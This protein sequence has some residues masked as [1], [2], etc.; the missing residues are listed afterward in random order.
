MKR[1]MIAVGTLVAMTLSACG[2]ESIDSLDAINSGQALSSLPNET[3][4]AAG[5]N[6]TYESNFA[7]IPKA[8][9]YRPAG[10]SKKVPGKR[11]VIFHLLGCGELAY[12]IAQGSGWPEA[13]EAYGLVI[14][15]P[16]IIAPSYPNQAAPNVACYNFG[17]GPVSAPTRNS[18]DH[19]ALI[20]AGQKVVT[21]YPA[22]QIDPN[23][24]YLAGLSAGATVGMQV[25]CMAPD[26]FAGVASVAGPAIG[27]DQS[28]AVMP[29]QVTSTQI[30]NQCTS[31]A[32]GSSAPNPQQALGQQLYIIVSDDNGL[33]AGNPVMENGV[34]T[35]DKFRKQTIWDG[36]KYVPHAY[37]D[38]IAG[39]MAPLFNA[40][41][42]GTLVTL[43]LSGTG[44]GCPGGDKSRDDTGE[45][46]CAFSAAVSRSWT[47]KAD[48][49]KDAQGRTRI[50][51]IE[52]DTL[53]HRWPA[54]P[55]GPNDKTV[56]P[57]RQTLISQGYILSDGTFD[58][59][60]L[61][62]APNGVIGGIYFSTD[63]FDFPMYLGKFLEDNNPR[64]TTNPPPTNPSAPVIQT[65]TENVAAG[66]LTV[67]GT[68]SD[69]DNDLAKVELS[70]NIPGAQKSLCTGTTSFTCKQDLTGVAAGN[71]SG[72]LTAT[73]AAGQTHSV[74]FSFTAGTVNPPPTGNKCV[75]AKNSAHIWGGR[76][77]WGGNIWFP[78]AFA[79]G[80]NDPLG[81][82]S[83]W[84]DQ[85]T[86][87]REESP[88]HWVKVASCP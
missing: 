83:F 41:K 28:R 48:A 24:V 42:S 45:T 69:K 77:T 20:A 12:Q 49:W 16:E 25:A 85:T 60:K 27:A 74:S 80:S 64:I 33:P 4:W 78:T 17:S 19:K 71:Y 55:V 29:P 63:S 31:Y 18:A 53:R 38:L 52:Q 58:I 81:N 7:G 68:A 37:H 84:N 46:E 56:T 8:W 47:A 23:Q 59:P 62:G 40:Q 11:G 57:D 65:H 26:I 67:T 86:S 76:A 2:G 88:G 13:A 6:W 15:V 3:S 14:V 79:K 9:V 1:A 82:A 21:D 32:N 35:A 36:D 51:H 39:A 5:T 72:T 61:N 34:W 43:P 75:T 30:K 66:S 10:F 70:T 22:L 87:V 44:T 50:L 54:G 73:D